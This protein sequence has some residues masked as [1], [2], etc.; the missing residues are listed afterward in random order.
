MFVKGEFLLWT[1]GLLLALFLL[2]VAFVTWFDKD[3]VAQGLTIVIAAAAVVGYVFRWSREFLIRMIVDYD[4][5]N[6]DG[7]VVIQRFVPSPT[8][9]EYV[10]FPLQQAAEGSPE[11][12]TRGLIN[13]LVTQLK[14]FRGLRA[15]T[16]GDLTLRGPAAPFGLTMRNIRDPA[17]VRGKLEAGWKKIAAIKAKEKAK[18]DREEEITRMRIAVT[19]G[20]VEAFK[21]PE[22]KSAI[23]PPPPPPPPAPPP[24]EWTPASAL[25]PQD[26]PPGTPAEAGGKPL[27]EP[28]D[29]SP[30]V[31]EGSEEDVDTSDDPA[32]ALRG[33]MPSPRTF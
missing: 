24:M 22:V 13:T 7:R 15:L 19:D 11:I 28:H 26:V 3:L 17:A 21:K 9:P 20:I 6:G 8:E 14:M 10:Q 16:I 12:N 23:A 27:P 29:T 30:V 4:A 33:R 1:G 32:A 18:R 5:N 25:R 2:A 31:E